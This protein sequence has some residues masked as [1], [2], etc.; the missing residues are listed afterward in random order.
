[1]EK[2]FKKR[3]LF[4][5]IIENRRQVEPIAHLPVYLD[6]LDDGVRKAACEVYRMAARIIR[7]R[8]AECLF[9]FPIPCLGAC[10]IQ[11]SLYLYGNPLGAMGINK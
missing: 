10:N 11:A 7:Q 9:R 1:M 3:L 5:I 6:L 8:F 2:R 4:V